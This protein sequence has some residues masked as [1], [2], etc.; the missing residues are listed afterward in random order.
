M[1][2]YKSDCTWELAQFVEKIA[3][4]EIDRYLQFE[5]FPSDEYLESSNQ[6]SRPPKFNFFKESPL[7]KNDNVLRSY[8]LEGMNWLCYN[9][10]NSRNSILV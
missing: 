2:E 3:K 8:Q 1:N 10:H 9:W 4:Q 6:D 7:F 5:M